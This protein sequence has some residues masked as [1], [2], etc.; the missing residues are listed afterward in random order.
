VHDL[1]YQGTAI[2]PVGEDLFRRLLSDIRKRPNPIL[3]Y[4]LRYV[5]DSPDLLGVHEVPEFDD[6]MHAREIILEEAATLSRA[7]TAERYRAPEVRS[8]L[9]RARHNKRSREAEAEIYSRNYQ[10]DIDEH[11]GSSAS[12]ALRSQIASSTAATA[13]A[14]SPWPPGFFV[15]HRD[16]GHP[17][18]IEAGPHFVQEVARRGGQE[19]RNDAVAQDPALGEAANRVESETDD[20]SALAH[21]IR[22]NG[23][24]R[25]VVPRE[26]HDR[27]CDLALKGHGHLSNADDAHARSLQVLVLRADAPAQ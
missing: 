13:P 1:F 7:C 6:L 8:M 19:A 23:N 16:R 4:T 24:K 14:R 21:G 15:P 12:F 18:R 25:D 17:G 2:N 5:L 3:N 22:D 10:K 26:G 20:R 9:N 11:F 27:V